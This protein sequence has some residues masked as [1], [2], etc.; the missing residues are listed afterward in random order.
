MNKPKKVEFTTLDA[1]GKAGSYSCGANNMWDNWEAYHKHI[2]TE[3]ADEGRIKRIIFDVSVKMIGKVPSG[4]TGKLA[5]K[6]SNQIK[7]KL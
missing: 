4:Y 6:L 2:L 7:E 1:L 3:L 5:K